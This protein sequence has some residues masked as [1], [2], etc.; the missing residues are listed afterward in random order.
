MAT[1]CLIH[2]SGQDSRAWDLLVRELAALG[3]EAI[4]PI[5]PTEE[6]EAGAARYAQ[7]VA[8]VLPPSQDVVVVAHSASGLFLPIVATFAPVARL[9]FL[10]AAIPVSGSSFLDQLKPDPTAM[11]NPDWIGQNPFGDDDAARTFL[12]NDC[13]PEVAA[14]ALTTRL[15]WYPARLYEEP[16]PLRAWPDVQSTYVVCTEDRTIQPEWSRRAA[17]ER[18]GVEAIDIPGGHCPHISRPRELAALLTSLA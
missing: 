9:V 16:C 8:E 18:L 11:F 2:G 6:A 17:K 4:A 10:A 7:A 1:F 14:W 13:T 5:L 12:F 15:D 3:L